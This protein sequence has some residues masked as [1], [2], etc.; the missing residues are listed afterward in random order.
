[1]RKLI[2]ALLYFGV[3]TPVAAVR[4]VFGDPLRRTISPQAASYWS[5]FD[6]DRRP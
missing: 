6:R 2:L 4:R 1:M 3:V 5:I